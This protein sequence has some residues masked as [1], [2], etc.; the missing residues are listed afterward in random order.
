MREPRQGGAASGAGE[1]QLTV[2]RVEVVRTY[3]TLNRPEELREPAP[4]PVEAEAVARIER[5]VPCPTALYQYLYKEVGGQWFWHS[6][7]AWSE[8]QLTAHLANPA[9]GVWTLTLNAE[10]AGFFELEKHDDGSVEIAY[11]GL[12]A[13][14]IGRGLGGVMLAR[15]AREAFGMGAS[16]LWLHTCTLDSPNAL[17]SY[18]ARG[19]RAYRTERIEVTVDGTTVLGERLVSE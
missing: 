15:A 9:I 4:L 13:P 2:R 17:P 1:V 3:L 7:L 12:R 18:Q 6:R 14:Y 11:F 8:E 19:F 10:L 16:R 5:L